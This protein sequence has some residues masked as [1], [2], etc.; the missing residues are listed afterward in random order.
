MGLGDAMGLEPGMG[1]ELRK[2]GYNFLYY[3]VKKERAS[4]A[5]LH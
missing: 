4:L 1:L 5:C 2:R 3:V